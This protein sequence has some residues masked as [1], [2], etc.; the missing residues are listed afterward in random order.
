MTVTFNPLMRNNVSIV[1]T[2]FDSNGDAVEGDSFVLPPGGSFSVRVDYAPRALGDLAEN[3]HFTAQGTLSQWE[4]DLAIRGNAVDCNDCQCTDGRIVIDMGDVAADGDSITIVQREINQNRSIC[5][6]ND[7][8]VKN[9]VSA[10]VFRLQNKPDPTVAPGNYQVVRIIFNPRDAVVFTDSI[11]FETTYPS[12]GVKCRFTVVVTG[13]GVRAA[14][15]VDEQAS[16][17]LAVDRT[18][19]PPTYRIEMRTSL[20]EARSGRICFYNC[21]NGGWLDLSRPQVTNA[22]GFTIPGQRYSLRA[23]AQGGG[24]ACFDVAFLPTEQMVWPNGRNSGPAITEF[25]TQF[26]VFGCEPST[27]RVVARVDTTPTSF[28]I[29]VFRWDQN[30]LNGYNFTPAQL[31]GSFIEDANA[32]D[33]AQPMITDLTYLSGPGGTLTG[34]VRI[35]SGW[36]LVRNNITD[37]AEFAYEAVRAWPEFDFLRLGI[38]TTDEELVM[39]LH[40]VYVVQIERAGITYLALVRVREISDDGQKQKLC[41]DVLFPV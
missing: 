12:N 37:Q 8:I 7:A 33:P 35:R 32:G 20:Q 9:F 11:V 24:T 21:G 30:R 23:R 10:D 36:K 5:L 4:V 38:N 1:A 19:N 13:R 40:S 17:N 26:T 18:T 3:I 2:V 39:V 25:T 6:R 22:E 28:S 27:V 41:L 14:C 15:C 16:E 34:R 29:C 31:R